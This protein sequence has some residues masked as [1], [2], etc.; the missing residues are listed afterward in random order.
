MDR[1][2]GIPVGGLAV[3]LAVILVAVAVTLG[4]LAVRNRAF[5]RLASR[6]V[7]R[8]R[9]RSALIVGGL[10]LA[11]A[12]ISS[13]LATGDTMARTVRSSA[14]RS[15][16]DTDETVVVAGAELSPLLQAEETT[17]SGWFDEGV[18]DDVRDAVAG[19]G[20]VDGVTPAVAEPVA[21]QNVSERRSEPRV[22]LFGADP[23][24]MRGF[25]E[26]S[27]PDGPA[28]LGQLRPGEVFVNG[29][30]ADDLGAG[31]GDRL[32]LYGGPGPT[33]VRVRDVVSYDGAGTDGAAVLAPLPL[34]QAALGEEGRVSQIRVSNTGGEVSGAGRT[35]EVV[36]LLRAAV[37]DRG[38]DVQPVKRDAL[39][40]AD[41]QGATFLSLFST[42]GTFAIAA[43]ILLI[44]LVFTMLAAERRSELGVARALGT[45][46]GH[47]IQTFL[48]EGALYDLLAAAVGALA[49]VA[50][51]NLMVQLVAAGFAG[52]DLT[53]E[54]AVRPTS[55]VLSFALGVLLTL[56]VVAVSAWRV[57]VLD[58]V[59]AIR[60]LPA[61]ARVRSRRAGWGL[62]AL[63][64]VVGGGLAASGASAAQATPFL[65]GVS[66]VI[67]G[68]VPIARALGAGERASHTIAGLALVV[69]WLLP[70]GAYEALVGKLSW[71][72]SVWIIA[73]LLVV[74]GATWTVM[75]NADAALAA[76]SR[77]VGRIRSL[78]PV[79]RMAV[80]YPLRSRLRT[81]MT[82]AMFTLVIF[83][84][85]TGGT[86]SG[87]FIRSLDDVERFGG[88]FDVRAVAAPVRPIGDLRTALRDSGELDVRDIEAVGTQSLVPIRARQVGVP[89][90]A[91][92][93]VRGVDRGFMA[94]TTY[95]FSTTATGYDSDEEVW[96]ALADE[97]NL[98]VVDGFTAPRRNN[99]AFGPQ[100]DFRLRGFNVEDRTFDP[101]EVEIRDPGSGTDMT[102]TVIGVLEDS[103]PIE[104]AGITTSQ[105]TLAPLGDRAQP[106]TYW[107]ELAPGVDADATAR[108]MESALFANGV[109]AR[110]LAD[111]LEETVSASWTINR[112]IQG[113]LGLGLVVGVV[114][115]GV[116]SAR[117]VVERRQQIGVLRAIGFQ[118]SMVRL[119]FLTEASFVALLA[120]VVGCALGLVVAY[121]VVAYAGTQQDVSFSVAWPDLLVVFSVV[122]LASLASTLAPAA[123]AARTYPAEVL[124]YE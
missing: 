26:I 23:E 82:L 85:V 103:T 69:W 22:T 119:A 1:L 19:S 48:Y 50:I 30:A 27:G 51:A 101:V 99:Y 70:S 73:G 29:D 92:Y 8:R 75:Y 67:V 96:R 88:G 10:M 98:A 65:L 17:R 52:E 18:A 124:R 46:R 49:G 121:N 97:P 39:D 66:I 59:T 55:L 45:Q 89:D 116:V 91:D 86:I 87:S 32:T 56:V 68:L 63:A 64:V 104:M 74:L 71:D 84:L 93:A 100:P 5:V 36:P 25:G 24:S 117:A 42:F 21:V 72:F 111:L 106:T 16:G 12:I 115:L 95:G 108:Q 62:G 54:R 94:T 20:L 15:L 122:Y 102:V 105:Q 123:R 110:S 78:A 79:I 28:T 13:S 43:G 76:V 11:T 37:E 118:P 53:L 77:G 60:N 80:A 47:L 58:V 57:S 61:R 4:V 112:L 107:I 14:L 83:T 31:P 35:D 44:F 40:R 6:N 2:A 90:F 34:A 120:I 109:E 38:L 41:E 9:G 33:E 114:A 81:S 7:T 3:A 113:F